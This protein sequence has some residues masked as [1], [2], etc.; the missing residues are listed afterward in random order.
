MFYIYD[1]IYRY[2]VLNRINNVGLIR[3][4]TFVNALNALT[5]MLCGFLFLHSLNIMLNLSHKKVNSS[6]LISTYLL[7]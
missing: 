3:Y 1:V 2:F 4:I 7:I 5:T 6:S